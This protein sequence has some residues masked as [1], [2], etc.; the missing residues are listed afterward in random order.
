LR[1]ERRHALEARVA[2]IVSAAVRVLPRRVVL[3]LGGALGDLWGALDRRHLRIAEDNL[4]RAFPDWDDDKVRSVARGVYA[5]FGRVLLDIVWMAGRPP[6]EL[7]AYTDVE[8]LEH[9]Q[10]ALRS[11]KGIVCPTAHFGNWEFQGVVSSLLVGPFSVIARPLDNPHLDRRLVDFRVSTGNTV[12][13]KKRAL[14]TAMKTIR[15][16]G[17]VAIVIDQNVQRR[18]G[19][20]VEF[21][22]R[23]ACT[24]T[25]AAA[26]ALKTGCVILPVR[27]P[28]GKDG[29]YRMIY[30]PPVEWEGGRRRDEDIDRLT[31]H[32]TS[33][34]EGWVR[35]SPEQWLWLHRRW[36]TQPEAN[37][38]PS[39]AASKEPAEGAR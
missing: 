34:I 31:Q 39:E 15:E 9:A 16:G 6:R 29:R 2:A 4:R 10:A 14:A 37:E 7:L 36:K 11:E 13:Y 33:V 35:E 28:M 21:F 3:A 17:A 5:H 32:L 26:V 18:D 20:F 30:G 12:L 19:I 24:T 27:C 23:P 22:G 8:G 25:V 1:R 38:A